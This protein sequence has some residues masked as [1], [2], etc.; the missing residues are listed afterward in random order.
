M[1]GGGILMDHGWHSLYLAYN[2][3]EEN[4]VEVQSRLHRPEPDAA[5]DEVTLKIRFP[6]GEATI[7]LTWNAGLRRNRMRLVGECGEIVIDDDI[8]K[9]GGE[10]IRFDPALSSG[11]Y[12]DDWF[13]AMLPDIVAAIRSPETAMP[14]LSEAAFCLQVIQ[15]AYQ[16]NCASAGETA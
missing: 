2:W 5:E 15:R 11:S 1:S 6:S 12:H 7:F 3:F 13:A 8:L 10:S 9:V 4:P 14:T 16:R